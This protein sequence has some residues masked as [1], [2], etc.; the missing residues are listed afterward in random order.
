MCLCALRQ[1]I[2]L[3]NIQILNT[4]NI[5]LKYITQLVVMDSSWVLSIVPAKHFHLFIQ[6]FYTEYCIYYLHLPIKSPVALN[7]S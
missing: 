7:C 1:R 4:L 2:Q 6:D 5:S 3:E